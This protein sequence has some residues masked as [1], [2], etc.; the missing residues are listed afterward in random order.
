MDEDLLNALAACAAAE[1]PHCPPWPGWQVTLELPEDALPGDI[2]QFT[3]RP[4]LMNEPGGGRCTYVD[5]W[6][7]RE[8]VRSD[9]ASLSSD[10]AC[11]PVPEPELSMPLLLLA[12]AIFA[13][14]GTR[15]DGA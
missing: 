1:P 7:E 5:A 14:L 15:E 13:W 12:F 6:T 2:H 4:G 9:V 3:V 11:V 8:G 10:A